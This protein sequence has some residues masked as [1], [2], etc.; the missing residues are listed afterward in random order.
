MLSL[1]TSLSSYI[2]AASVEGGISAYIACW[3]VGS[4]TLRGTRMKSS[5]LGSISFAFANCLG[6]ASNVAVGNR[7]GSARLKLDIDLV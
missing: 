7:D 6:I 5:G 4:L 1:K 3:R 2:K